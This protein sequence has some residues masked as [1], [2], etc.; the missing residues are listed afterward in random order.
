MKAFHPTNFARLLQQCATAAAKQR[1][2]EFARGLISA[3]VFVIP[4]VIREAAKGFAIVEADRLED[5]AGLREIHIP[6]GAVLPAKRCILFFEKPNGLNSFAVFLAQEASRVAVWLIGI[7]GVQPLASFEAGGSGIEHAIPTAE[8]ECKGSFAAQIGI[9]AYSLALIGQPRHV[10]QDKLSRDDA[11]RA[12]RALRH[13]GFGRA[14]QVWTRISWN[15]GADVVAKLSRDPSFHPMP[16]HFRRAHWRM[17]EAH[18]LDA[19]W[20]DGV[21]APR[22]AGWYIRVPETWPGHPAF[23]IKTS[24][25]APK[26]PYD[27]LPAKWAAQ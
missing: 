10:R 5:L 14:A 1:S 20:L 3:Q 17:A 26:M 16:L 27:V 11:R 21:S 9:I 2:S 25:H 4:D 18:W 22:G 8:I 12:G 6:L 15:I 19:V 24:Y 23:G 7:Q 13:W